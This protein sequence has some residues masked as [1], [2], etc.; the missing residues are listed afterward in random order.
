MQS[1]KSAS[2]GLE[3]TARSFD[4]LSAIVH[5]SQPADAFAKRAIDLV[6]WLAR[7]RIDES[8]FKKCAELARAIAYPNQNGLTIRDSIEQADQ[9][10]RGIRAPIGLLV[11]GSL[12]RIMI[13][14]DEFCYMVSSVASLAPFY[15]ID[16]VS[17]TFC[18]MMLKDEGRWRYQ[19]QRAPIKAVM[20]KIV[21]SIFIN[22]INAGHHSISLPE[23][24]RQLHVH[25]I[26]CVT[27]ASIVRMI[28]EAQGNIIIR[29]GHFLGDIT[30]W[31]L[32]HFHGRLHVYLKNEIIFSQTLGSSEKVVHLMVQKSCDEQENC[33][34]REAHVELSVAT[35]DGGYKVLLEATDIAEVADSV[36]RPRTRQP[37]YQVDV[38]EDTRPARITNLTRSEKNHVVSVAKKMLSWFVSLSVEPLSVPCSDMTLKVQLYNK[39]SSFEVSNLLYA[40]PNLLNRDTGH[41]NSS[42]PVFVP[43]SSDFATTDSDG[44][45][46]GVF[47]GDED[48]PT[49]EH[50]LVCFP[51]AMDM[52]ESIQKRCT[53]TV[54]EK[55]G[56]LEDAKVGCLRWLAVKELFVLLAHGI[57][58][59]LGATDVS[60]LSNSNDIVTAMVVML[61]SLFRTERLHWDHLFAI[62]AIT[63]LGASSQSIFGE[64]VS[65]LR[66]GSS[67]FIAVQNGSL[68]LVAPWINVQNEV[69][70]KGCFHLETFEGSIQGVS[71]DFA[72]LSCEREDYR[73]EYPKDIKPTNE[74]PEQIDTD[75]VEPMTAVFR[76]GD[77]MY[78]LATFVKSGIRLRII[79][80]SLILDSL[81][82][83]TML[84]CS[85]HSDSALF[86]KGAPTGS[87][88]ISKFE[89]V[90]AFWN[91][92]GP[93]KE[94]YTTQILNDYLKINTVLAVSPCG[95]FVCPTESCCF[96]C[97]VKSVQKAA[98]KEFD[99]VRILR[100]R[101]HSR[102]RLRST[103]MPEE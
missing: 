62:S 64:N 23:E 10:L 38:M 41:L 69:S 52:I 29:S 85:H 74:V 2:P 28:D 36:P 15:G 61:V 91:S 56:P 79:N 39:K 82:R 5:V 65:R 71:E 66:T 94:V 103:E 21:E 81:L 60:G 88:V 95:V 46:S 78:R 51:I 86:E 87:V 47:D 22:V 57:S 48:S 50:V 19:A 49:W 11:S 53:C 37:L 33:Y 59:G 63:T 80:P 6:K 92:L 102:L 89:E 8:N 101:R 55:N 75:E 14:D 77:S 25:L 34:R 4:L 100:M 54:C 12:G 16:R 18:S 3:L 31:L 67:S 35:S 96:Q 17:E 13:R 83:T 40:Y 98:K 45:D 20:T 7:E 1:S 9:K 84:R 90:L 70:V 30:S 72:L 44:S 76:V 97:A 32:N 24:L 26:D 93:G 43:P 42:A 27:F 99:P 68:V 58:E 73:G